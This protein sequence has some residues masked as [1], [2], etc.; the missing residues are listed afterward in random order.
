MN[1]LYRP[2][3]MEYIPSFINRKHGREK[4]V[5]DIPVME[6]YPE[7]YLRDHGLPGAGHAPFAG[8]GR[9][10]QRAGR[11]AAQSD[12]KEDRGHDE[13]AETEVLRGLPR[14]RPRRTGR[15]QRYGRTGKPLPI[16]PSTNHIPPAMPTSPTAWPT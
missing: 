1:A 16:T 3:P 5:Y 8:T 14:K 6:K 11:L 9:L 12:G 15:R 2:G 10:H 7:G 13:R 4:I